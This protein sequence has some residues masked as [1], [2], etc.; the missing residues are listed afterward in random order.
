MTEGKYMSR[1][2]TSATT[3]DLLRK[4]AKRWLKGLRENDPEARRRYDSAHPAPRPSP[5]LRDVQL[6]LAHEYG[7]PG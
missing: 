4:E 6:A 3:L 7:Q 5:G 2:L 1:K